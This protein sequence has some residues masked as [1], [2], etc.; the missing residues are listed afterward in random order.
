MNRRVFDNCEFSANSGHFLFGVSDVDTSLTYVEN[1]SL[2]KL[3]NFCDISSDRR[4]VYV[5][6][7]S[8]L[9]RHEN[10]TFQAS[11]LRQGWESHVK[12]RVWYVNGCLAWHNV[13]V[14]DWHLTGFFHSTIDPFIH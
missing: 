3:L 11:G 4:P 2:P 13:R 8:G 7:I 9:E 5:I 12:C 14:C 1:S 6:M 10:P